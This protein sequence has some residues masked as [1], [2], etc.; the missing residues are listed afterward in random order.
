MNF[1]LARILESK[2]QHRRALAALPIEEMLRL[3]DQEP[4][5]DS[6][7][8]SFSEIARHL[9][10][11]FPDTEAFPDPPPRPSHHERPIPE[12]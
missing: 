12:F 3:L 1:D 6:E 5:V 8:N 4:A 7:F 2:R 9:A 10:E 11:N